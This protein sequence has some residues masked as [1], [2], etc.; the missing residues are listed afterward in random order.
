MAREANRTY[1]N[2]GMIAEQL[3]GGDIAVDEE[4]V[5]RKKMDKQLEWVKDAILDLSNRMDEN[6]GGM[7]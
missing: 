3:T 5:F 6:G 2:Y 4:S 1:D 7:I